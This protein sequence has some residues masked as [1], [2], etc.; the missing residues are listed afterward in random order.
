VSGATDASYMAYAQRLAARGLY[1]VD[2]NPRVGCVIAHG[3]EI[4]GAGHH[5]AA[6]EAHAEAVAL[7]HAGERARGATAYVTLEPCCHHGRTPPCTEALTAGGIARVVY[8]MRD[9]DPRVAGA[10]ARA[11]SEAG[12]AVERLDSAASEARQLN[13][14]YIK[15]LGAGRPWIRVKL[16]A[17]LDGRTALASGESRWITSEAARSDGH[18]WRARSSWVLTGRATVAADD[19]SLDVRLSARDFGIDRPPHQPGVAIVDTALRTDPAAR[20]FDSHAHSVVF[21]GP[22]A[23]AGAAERL[24]G[25]GAEVVTVAADE[26]RVDVAAVCAELA[27]RGANEVHV[28]AGSTLCGH[29]LSTGYIDELILYMA[30]ALLGDEARGLFAMPALASMSERVR[31]HLRDVRRVGPDLAVRALPIIDR[32]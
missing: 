30:P 24:R 12:I 15:R 7:Q 5:A 32:E 3:E 6:G 17:S 9:P 13:I 16:A 26:R 25:R 29:L 31:L 22:D 28:E 27:R 2:G 4:V 8:A 10:G 1:T 19:P 18:R 11:L 23:D 14:G 21:C 20:A